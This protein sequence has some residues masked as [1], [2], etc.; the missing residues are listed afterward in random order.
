M[1][2][3]PF[4]NLREALIKN[5]RQDN[6]FNG[7]QYRQIYTFNVIS[8]YNLKYLFNTRIKQYMV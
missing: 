7:G 1:Q 2:K 5:Q 8:A 4:K 3:I 6:S